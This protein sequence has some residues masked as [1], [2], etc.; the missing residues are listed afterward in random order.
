M[1]DEPLT[2]LKTLA[3]SRLVDDVVA[4]LRSYMS[5]NGLED[6]SRLP[7]ER[8][9]AEVLGTSRAT[10]AQ[11]LRVLAVMGLVEIRHGSGIYVR[12]DPGTLFGTTFDLMIDLEPGSVGQLAEFRYWIEK[13]ILADGHVPPVDESR[14]LED[15]ETLT[16][17]K[18]RLESWIEADAGF[19]VTLVAATGNEY[20]HSTYEMAH[21]KILSVSY[22]DWI[23]RGSVPSWLKGERWKG[24]V[25]L[26]RRILDAA[27]AGDAT[28]LGSA[29]AAHQAEIM[30][31]LA[32]AVDLHLPE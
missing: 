4:H 17:S 1:P 22:S 28:A 27:L 12:R 2:P 32:R 24:Q 14:L 11:A 3:P 15:F 20:L 9:L 6:G 16:L 26:H 29:L 19:H 10:V 5:E 7:S 8:A 25:D 13:S 31:H 23:E 18:S 30:N 21:R